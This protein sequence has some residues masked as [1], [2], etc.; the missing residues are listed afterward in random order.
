MDE[1][2]ALELSKLRGSIDVQN[3]LQEEANGIM[4]GL[5]EALKA[6]AQEMADARK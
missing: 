4:R 5:V 2:V 1:D 6:V 3:E